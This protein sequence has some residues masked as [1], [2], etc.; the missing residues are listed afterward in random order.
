MREAE[1]TEETATIAEK[2]R[3]WEEQDRINQAII[4]RLLKMHESLDRLSRNRDMTVEKISELEAQVKVAVSAANRANAV[5]RDLERRI[6]SLA[7]HYDRLPVPS[8]SPLLSRSQQ[9]AVPYWLFATAFGLSIAGYMA[10][11]HS[12]PL[13]GLVIVSLGLSAVATATALLSLRAR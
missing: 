10:L 2:V 5:L 9:S 12:G 1:A 4:P 3:F 7:S 13:V 6:E 11:R 8:D